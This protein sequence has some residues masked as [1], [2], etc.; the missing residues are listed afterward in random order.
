MKAHWFALRLALIAFFSFAVWN[1]KSSMHL[2]PFQVYF[3]LLIGVLGARFWFMRDY[4]REGRVEPWLAPSWGGPLMDQH[5]PMQF[6]HAAGYAFLS[7]GLSG[8]LRGPVS[9]ID[10]AA[11]GF[12]DY[13]MPG[14]AGAGL[15]LGMY[16]AIWSYPVQFGLRTRQDG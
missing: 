6:V 1:S 3:F 11:P 2:E 8:W 13:L 5:Q 14:A 9:V 15:L 12:P 7:A 10:A 16:W 4:H